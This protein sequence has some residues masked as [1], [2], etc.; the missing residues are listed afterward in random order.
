MKTGVGLLCS[1][2]GVQ[3]HNIRVKK[4]VTAPWSPKQYPEANF[5]VKVCFIVQTESSF[6]KGGAVSG[7]T[8]AKQTTGAIP[9][10]LTE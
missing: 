7:E 4:E 5:Q 3:E 10:S 9:N 1:G 2:P 8:K 6:K